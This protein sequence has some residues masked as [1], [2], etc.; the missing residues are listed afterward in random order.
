MKRTTLHNV[1][2]LR[3]TATG[4]VARIDGKWHSVNTWH[5]AVDEIRFEL[6]DRQIKELNLPEDGMIWSNMTWKEE[7]ERNLDFHQDRVNTAK[8]RIRIAERDLEELNGCL[9]SDID[10]LRKAEKALSE[11][12]GEE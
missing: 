9:A 6:N 7:L 1:T 4:S 8:E 12:D 10:D 3:N 2:D 11:Y 5:G